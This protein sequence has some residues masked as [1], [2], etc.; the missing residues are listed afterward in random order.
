MLL[1][2]ATYNKCIQATYE[3]ELDTIQNWGCMPF[4]QIAESMSTAREQVLSD[5]FFKNMTQGRACKGWWDG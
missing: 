5:V 2:K 3:Q 4:K 1:S